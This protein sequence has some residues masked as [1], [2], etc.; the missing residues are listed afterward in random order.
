V[1]KGTPKR[2]RSTVTPSRGLTLLTTWSS[3]RSIG[4]S[5]KYCPRS[6]VAISPGAV[7][8]SASYISSWSAKCSGVVPVACRLG[9][10]AT[11]SA[12][13]TLPRD[14]GGRTLSTAPSAS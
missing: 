2:S 8:L 9:P 6:L 12:T 5:L 1:T 4:A 11:A 3:G 13:S 10:T 14:P 7:V